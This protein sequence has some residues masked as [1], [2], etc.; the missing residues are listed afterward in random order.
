DRH[1]EA[2]LRGTRHV[3]GL[4]D[5]G[6]RERAIS[7]REARR[8]GEL[9]SS[10]TGWGGFG[11]LDLVLS[12]VDRETEATGEALREAE[13]HTRPD[14]ILASSSLTASPTRAQEGLERPERVVALRFSRP[15]DLF[16][17]VE[18]VPGEATAGAVVDAC[19]EFVLRLGRTPVV[20]PDHPDTVGNRLLGR[21]L[22]EALRILDGGTGAGEV[23]EAVEAFGFPLGPFRRMDAMGV[24]RSLDLLE[25]LAG[26]CGERMR[27]SE[28]AACLTGAP[29][30]FY[31]YE[32]G[33]PRA[34][35]P[36]LPAGPR[37]PTPSQAEAIQ[38]R[39]LLGLV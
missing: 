13:E 24:P 35:N 19:R 30:L 32:R 3:L 11:T 10:A 5:R 14:C 31:R 26:W 2:L 39:L 34:P 4:L 29:L 7:A 15:T 9:V 27:P 16:P 22:A 18:I 36:G 23:D 21:L 6:E 1:R 17:L 33:L 12:A 25:R 28:V 37:D 8:R 20:V 38:T